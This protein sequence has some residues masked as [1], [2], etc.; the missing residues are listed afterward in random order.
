MDEFVKYFAQQ[1]D[2]TDTTQ[3]NPDTYFRDFDEW[4]S[5]TGLCVM[6]MIYDNY[7]VRIKAED[8]RKAETI[9][10]VF[11]LVKQSLSNE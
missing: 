11:N 5:L 7:K 2:E 4:S 6:S 3:F 9:G 1:F 10:D 8:M